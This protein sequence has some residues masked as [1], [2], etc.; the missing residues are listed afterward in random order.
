MA[1]NI[2]N[3]QYMTRYWWTPVVLAPRGP[4]DLMDHDALGLVA[5]G[6]L[7]IRTRDI[8]P[9]HLRP[10]VSLV[11]RIGRALRQLS[12]ASTVPAPDIRDRQQSVTAPSRLWRL[13]QLGFFPDTET[14]WMPFAIAAAI[15]AH[16]SER[17]DALHST[18]SPVTVAQIYRRR[19][20]DAPAISV[21]TNGHD[22]N[23]VVDGPRPRTVPGRFLIVWTGTLY[24]PNELEMFL[25]ALKALIARRPNVASRLAVLFYGHVSG[26][27]QPI[28]GRC[29]R[30]PRLHGVLHFHGFVP[31]R[32]TLEALADADAALVMLGD[33]PGIG[34]FVPGKLFDYIGQSKQVLAVLPPGDARKILEELDWGV[35]ANPDVLEIGRAIERLLD[36]PP[37]KR[38][39]D[40]DG[41]Y[42]SR[43]LARRLADTLRSTAERPSNVQAEVR[44]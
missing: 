35:I 25:E 17:F 43:T 42:D 18:S 6:T 7:V 24:R 41:R 38:R 39:A 11:R 3:V 5:S 31:R 44:P 8:G 13:Q 37:P 4:G 1:R 30:D 14:G 40:P 22:A 33:G 2:R 36:L 23:E 20:P 27:C 32:A 10:A 26:S 19:Y 9:R 15:R 21:V 16:R 29:G 28:A 12:L 34:Q